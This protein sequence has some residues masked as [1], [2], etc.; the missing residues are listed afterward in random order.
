ME[1]VSLVSSEEVEGIKCEEVLPEEVEHIIDAIVPQMKGI[2]KVEEHGIGLA[3]PQVGIKKKFFIAWDQEA[4]DWLPYFNAFYVKASDSRVKMSEG[5]LSYKS[6]NSKVIKRYKSIKLIH[7]E[8]D[9]KNLTRKRKTL[10]G[11]PAIVMQH[12]CDHLRG[13]TIYTK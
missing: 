3:A 11:I 13:V 5:C 4:K 6:G 10:R 1:D 8:W 12:E 7:D 2:L 9:G